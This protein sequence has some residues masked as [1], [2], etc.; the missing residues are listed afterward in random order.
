M[1]RI[2]FKQKF[3]HHNKYTLLPEL[4]VGAEFSRGGE[5][6]FL[7]VLILIALFFL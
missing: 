5:R 7:I 6:P 3:C 1:K 4:H 2:R